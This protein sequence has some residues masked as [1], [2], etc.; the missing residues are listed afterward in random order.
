MPA[1]A[2]FRR[3]KCWEGLGA[4][5]QTFDS[6]EPEPMMSMTYS[7]GARAQSSGRHFATKPY[8]W[9]FGCMKTTLELPD[10]LMRTI[11]IRA[12]EENRKLEDTIAGWISSF[13]GKKKPD[14]LVPTGN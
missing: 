10:D 6:Q 3:K 7:S 9:Y 5:F 8:D 11:K 12:V 13:L 4:R 2:S 1:G 14:R